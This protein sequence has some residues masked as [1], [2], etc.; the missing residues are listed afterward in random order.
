MASAEYVPKPCVYGPPIKGYFHK[1]GWN[2]DK[3]YEKNPLYIELNCFLHFKGKARIPH[4][5]NICAALWPD[6]QGSAKPFY[7]SPWTEKMLEA[8]CCHNYLSVMGSGSSGKTQFFAVWAIVNYLCAPDKTKVLVTSTTI[9]DGRGRI[10]GAICDYWLAVPGLPGKLVNSQGVIRF[11]QGSEFSE[12]S[13]IQLIPGAP[14]KAKESVAKMIGFKNDRLI[15]IADELPELSEAIV[16]AGL[17]NLAL[18]PYFQLVGLGNPKNWFDPM[19][20][21]TAPAEGNIEQ[22]TVDTG[23]WKTKLGYNLHFDGLKSPNVEAG[24]EIY[25]GLITAEKVR[26]AAKQMGDNSSG[27][28]RMIR[29]WPS[30]AGEDDC[31]YSDVDIRSSGSTQTIGNGFAWLDN[32]LT[33][34]AALDPAFTQ[35]GDRSMMIWGAMGKNIEGK[36]TLLVLGH[37]TLFED[38][39]NKELNHSQ[40]IISQFKNKCDKLGVQPRH[41]AIDATGGGKP[42]WDIVSVMITR[43]VLAIDF[44]GAP[45]DAAVSA[46]DATPAKDRYKNRVSEL[47]WGGH[48]YMRTGQIKGISNELANEMCQ[49]KKSEEKGN[50]LQLKIRVESKREMKARNLPSPDLADAFFIM[51]ELC[52]QRLGFDSGTVVRKTNPQS[53]DSKTFKQL[54]KRFS[55]VYKAA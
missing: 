33:M 46:Y 49:R 39:T 32:N 8:A 55:D 47:W 45:S 2:W 12:R 48:E 9:K 30:P 35:G 19:S 16:E 24:R 36:K 20:R 34:V 17:S 43:D 11:Q 4:F 15:L 3:V 50:G 18:N 25:R 37:E 40:Q 22:L 10:W 44:G 1:Y 38:A 54:F 41:M 23:Q 29:G 52:R 21:M 5:K 26:E 42:F 28:W 53:G 7:F 14:T 6:K 51:V 13:G 27:W 31:V